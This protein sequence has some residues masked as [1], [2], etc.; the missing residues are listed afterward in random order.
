MGSCCTKT[1]QNVPATT[2]KTLDE[3]SDHELEFIFE[4]FDKNSNGKISVAEF[5][6][7]IKDTKEDA[8]F[9]AVTNLFHKMDVDHN[10]ALDYEEFK[11]VIKALKDGAVEGL[12]PIDFVKLVLA[13]R[14]L[15][16]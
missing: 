1:Y 6:G 4:S 9:G 10:R 14:W 12:P 5:C 16:A 8:T 13:S 3:P 2:T 11:A 7:A 15:G